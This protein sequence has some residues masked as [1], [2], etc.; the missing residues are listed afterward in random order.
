MFLF[1]IMMKSLK[2]Q[3]CLC[4]LAPQYLAVG[5]VIIR[6]WSHPWW[7]ISWIS[8]SCP[9]SH[10]SWWPSLIILSSDPSWVVHRLVTKEK[11]CLQ[12]SN[13]IVSAD[14]S[15]LILESWCVRPVMNLL[16]RASAELTMNVSVYML[17]ACCSQG[18]SLDFSKPRDQKYLIIGTKYYAI[19]RAI[20]VPPS[21]RLVQ[22]WPTPMNLR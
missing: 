18:G 13:C 19:I 5:M 8:V 16:E 4:F 15:H 7:Q 1:Y 17:H 6:G 9:S 20:T 14:K 22:S 11:L 12:T 2:K 10:V 3:S 21:L